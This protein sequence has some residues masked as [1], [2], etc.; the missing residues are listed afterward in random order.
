MT[1]QTSQVFFYGLCQLLRQSRWVWVALCLFSSACKKQFAAEPLST[2]EIVDRTAEKMR[3]IQSFHYVI[4][5][6]GASAF[7]DPEETISFRQ[8]E[9]YFVAPDRTQAVVRVIGPGI[10]TDVSIV[11]IGAVQWQTNMATGQWE[12][13]PPD[14]GFNPSLLFDVDLGIPNLLVTDLT[15]LAILTATTPNED[16]ARGTYTLEGKIAGQ[17]LY[18]ISQGLMGPEPMAITIWVESEQFYLRRVRLI[19]PPRVSTEEETIW[20]LEFDAFDEPVEIVPP[21]E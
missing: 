9:G 6:T 4:D 2:K 14:M 15:D 18:D 19:E 8:A 17:K 11:S 1:L 3:Q 5:R 13:L 12:E 21:G 10:V 20:Q 16:E 7:L